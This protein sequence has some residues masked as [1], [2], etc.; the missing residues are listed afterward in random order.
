MDTKPAKPKRAAKKAATPTEKTEKPNGT[1]RK[2]EAP[3]Q[4]NTVETG[5]VAASTK[6]KPR[7]KRAPAKSKAASKTPSL[8]NQTVLPEIRDIGAVTGGIDPEILGA[9]E[10]T[11]KFELDGKT[12]EYA[13]CVSVYDGDTATFALRILPGTPVFTFACRFLGYNSPEKKGKD[14][15]EEEKA[16]G[17]KSKAALESKILGQICRLIVGDPVNPKNR[18]PYKRPLVTVYLG[19]RNI[20][21]EMMAEGY[22]IAYSGKGEKKW[23]ADVG[24]EL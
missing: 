24:G 17:S 3:Q 22:G 21:A 9:N 8:D 20:N 1:E 4:D 18:D 5:G 19:D 23:K 13:K 16:L 14:V 15:S 6:A 7:A 12:Y 2:N 11:P 10:N